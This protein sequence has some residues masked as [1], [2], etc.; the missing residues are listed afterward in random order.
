MHLTA[1][2]CGPQ[3]DVL[4]AL[5]MLSSPTLPQSWSSHLQHPGRATG[6]AYSLHIL[7]TY[8]IRIHIFTRLPGELY[9][10][11]NLR[12]TALLDSKNYISVYKTTYNH[13]VLCKVYCIQAQ[14]GIFLHVF[15][16]CHS[17][18]H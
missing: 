10:L 5:C 8:Q 6:K 7:L 9:G 2:I 11:S 16:I 17:S 15:R 14:N 3:L 13:N 4:N 12:S 18:F 1:D